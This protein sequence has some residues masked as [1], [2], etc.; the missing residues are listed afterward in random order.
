MLA[1]PATPTASKPVISLTDFAARCSEIVSQH[2]GHQ[3]HRQLDL[4]VTETLCSLGYSEGMAIFLAHV[5]DYHPEEVCDTCG[6]YGEV[7]GHSDDCE[8]DLCALAGGMDDCN[9]QI[10]TCHCFTPTPEP[11]HD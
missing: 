2:S 5:S 6:G 1:A 9:G 4:L 8:S 10:V 7:Y 11:H 3:A